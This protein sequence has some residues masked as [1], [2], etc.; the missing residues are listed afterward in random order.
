M[1]VAALAWESYGYASEVDHFD[2]FARSQ[3]VQTTDPFAGCPLE[4]ERWQL[5]FMGEALAV[6]EDLRRIWRSVVL[7]VSRKN[8]K[9]A[10]L[11]AY[12]LYRLLMDDGNPEILLAAASDKNARR[13]FDAVVGY[14]RANPDLEAQLHIR[15]Y[16]GEIVRAD[17]RGKIIRLATDPT[18]LHGYNPSLVICDELHAWTKPSLR[19]VWAALTTAGGARSNPQVF[20][21][22]TAGEAAQRE[23]SILGRMLTTN[24]QR[25]ELEKRPGLTISRNRA[26]QMLIY[27]YSAPTKEPRDFAAMKLANPASWISTEYLRRQADN[28]ELSEAEVLQF[29]G[30]VWA[31]GD[32]TWLDPIAFAELAAPRDVDLDE[33]PFVAAFDGSDTRDSTVIVGATV[34]EHPYVWVIAAW[35]RPLELAPKAA[36]RVPRGD[37]VDTIE[38]VIERDGCRE[39]APDP[40]G[41][42]REIEELEQTYG[43]LVVRFETNQPR[44]MGPACDDFTQGV[45]G[46]GG[47]DDD[48]LGEPAPRGEPELSHDGTELLVRHLGHCCPVKRGGYTL[49]KKDSDDSPR[50]IDAAVGAIVAYHR[51]RWLYT[52]AEEEDMV[53]IVVEPPKPPQPKRSSKPAAP[54]RDRRRRT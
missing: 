22:T 52:N 31:K 50:K 43:D 27:N 45:L 30:C 42:R 19:K 11:A 10:L 2:W 1:P 35:E 32:S 41:W 16:E 3:V 21:I 25:G 14:A 15:E 51:A 4:L 7:V 13:L 39:F 24:E 37:V 8:G 17:G 38:R 53:A 12:A 34:E 6:D 48:E 9:T 54:A 46:P 20:T 28:P 47:D 26:G 44:R 29:H 36:W 18:V 40:P 23:T 49:V 33:T 5:E